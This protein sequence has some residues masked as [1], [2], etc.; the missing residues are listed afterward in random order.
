MT[1]WCDGQRMQRGV[2]KAP[3]GRV[4]IVAWKTAA[5]KPS[6][7]RIDNIFVRAFVDPE[8]RPATTIDVE[9]ARP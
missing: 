7:I 2:L 5:V 9:V 6:P 4:S 1:V 3:P 8:E